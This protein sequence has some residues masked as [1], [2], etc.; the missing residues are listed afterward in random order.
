MG[1]IVRQQ[2][3]ATTTNLYQV[4]RSIYDQFGII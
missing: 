1:G 4:T 3:P 2:Q